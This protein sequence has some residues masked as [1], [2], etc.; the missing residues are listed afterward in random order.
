VPALVAF[1]R[2][3]FPELLPEKAATDWQIALQTAAA[4]FSAP[5]FSR[6]CAPSFP[7][8]LF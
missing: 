6:L 5:V 1:G 8:P 7:D 4:I 3:E 2:E